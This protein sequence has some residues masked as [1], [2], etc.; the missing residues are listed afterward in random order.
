ME[1]T[2]GTAFV[3][4]TDTGVR[5][6]PFTLVNAE[7]VV[8]TLGQY[9]NGLLAGRWQRWYSNG[10]KHE[11][12][13]FQEGKLWGWWTRW[14]PNGRKSEEGE[15]R[16]NDEIG[17]WRAW[18]EHGTLVS[19]VP[20][21]L[22]CPAGLTWHGEPPLIDAFS[23]I[24]GLSDGRHC[25]RTDD[26]PQGPTVAW[27]FGRR[28]IQMVGWYCDGHA[29]GPW[30]FFWPTGALAREGSYAGPS[31]KQGVWTDWDD[32]GRKI[33]EVEYDAGREIA[34]RESPKSAEPAPLDV[35]A[36]EELAVRRFRD[37]EKRECAAPPVA[38]RPYRGLREELRPADALLR[39]RVT[40]VRTPDRP[41]GWIREMASPP[42]EVEAR[43]KKVLAGSLC[44]PGATIRLWFAAAPHYKRFEELHNYGADAFWNAPHRDWDMTAVVRRQGTRLVLLNL[45]RADD[46]MRT[47]AL[48]TEY[49]RLARLDDRGFRLGLARLIAPRIRMDRD[50]LLWSSWGRLALDDWDRNRAPGPVDPALRDL[51]RR[52]HDVVLR[53]MDRYLATRCAT[54]LNL[55]ELPWLIRL[56]SLAERRQT[57]AR[58]LRAHDFLV[59]EATRAKE[60]EDTPAAAPPDA[61]LSI[62]NARQV[63]AAGELYRVLSCLS[64]CIDPDAPPNDAYAKDLLDRARSFVN[65]RT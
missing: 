11:V 23:P 10:A 28:K 21:D 62:E 7:G 30:S 51:V 46:E 42:Q 54:M 20:R 64:V 27:G 19:Q 32:R 5:H 15:Y 44:R 12:G 49:S 40:D 63:W 55:D 17:V 2:G 25:R 24:H 22:V 16:A 56:L 18:D 58:L 53:Q 14:H 38:P 60:T 9:D 29:Q 31:R 61:G 52:T 4:V 1:R 8:L 37:A 34:R 50:G 35:A 13:H 6:G 41:P 39:I 59:R 3:C 36:L 26:V 47:D 45:L 65:P 43:V 33:V 57:A 48:L